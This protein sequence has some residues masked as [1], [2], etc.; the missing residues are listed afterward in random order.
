MTTSGYDALV[1]QAWEEF[2]ATLRVR[3][4][5]LERG[6]SIEFAL[7]DA[8]KWRTLIEVTVTGS[9][10]VRAGIGS[11]A[12][13]PMLPLNAIANRLR[14]TG[15]G[16]WKKIRHQVVYEVGRRTIDDLIAQIIAALRGL[17]DLPHPSF[18]T[19]HDPFGPRDA[20]APPPAVPDAPKRHLSS[21]PDLPSAQP[22]HGHADAH[23][24]AGP[25][26]DECSCPTT[27]AIRITAPDQLITLARDVL[28][29]LVHR[30]LEIDDH[31]MIE[32]PLTDEIASRVVVCEAGPRLEFV[33]TLG[34]RIPPAAVL[35]QLVTDYSAR[36]S[37]VTLVIDN[38][39]LFAR[40]SLECAV[41]HPDNLQAAWQLW[42][43][44]VNSVGRDIVSLLNG[45][46]P[47]T[48]E[49]AHSSVPIGMQTL[50]RIFI[51][52]GLSAERT[53]HLVSGKV[54]RL[55]EYAAVCAEMIEEW[56]TRENESRNRHAPVEDVQL[57]ATM[58]A[59]LTIFATVLTEA[60]L[61][62]ERPTG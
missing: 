40:Y 33:A 20:P 58:A 61:L 6:Q 16:E 37:H 3:F 54:D 18:V 19:V 11:P 29:A 10:R 34:H 44:F 26:D 36:L 1:E 4:A 59:D 28:S 60:I 57:C 53:A 62:L 27:T 47:G 55:R 41:F 42:M 17:W 39:H 2:A 21:V 49:C 13:Q 35:A 9:K 38:G 25:L 12:F 52:D 24:N 51:E 45:G 32:L 7:S 15:A 50:L 48:H 46:G 8:T 14:E 22:E 5:E 43:D 23:D 30:E 56:R 31:E